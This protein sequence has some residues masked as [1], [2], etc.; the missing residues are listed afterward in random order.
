M[1]Q[2]FFL[3]L[4]TRRHKNGRSDISAG[5]CSSYF[6]LSFFGWIYYLYFYEYF[7]HLNIKKKHLHFSK[8]FKHLRVS[9]NFS[10]QT[11]GQN[12]SR[13]IQPILMTFI[14]HILYN[15]I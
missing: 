11:G 4:G 14:P 3:Q 6:S 1:L 10:F 13:S 2:Q 15:I 9:R 5:K 12:I 8:H 7:K